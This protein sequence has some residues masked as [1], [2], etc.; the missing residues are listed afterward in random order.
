MHP[1]KLTLIAN[2][3]VLLEYKGQRYLIDGIHTNEDLEFDGVPQTLLGQMLC[4][5]GDLADIDY[6]LFTHEHIDHF[7][8]GLTQ[9]YLQNN[10]VKAIVVPAQ[11]GG[12]LAG[13]KEYAE[14]TGVETIAPVIA[15]GEGYTTTLGGAELTVGGMRHMGARFRDVQ[16]CSLLLDFE[17]KTLLF[18]GDSDHIPK[19]FETAFEGK[20]I[21]VMFVNPLFYLNPMGQAVIEQMAPSTLVI[22]HLAQASEGVISPFERAVL[23][24]A[25][26]KGELPY[27]LILLDR[28][29]QT[30]E[31]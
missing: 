4:G 30:E 19:W 26:K 28:M 1:V 3:G 21:D 24:E 8:A 27:Q 16:S 9:T 15:D 10:N 5:S 31:F 12:R 13:L 29:G 11:G 17:G 23:A 18:T 2:A 22:Y 25:Q 7:M 6:L 14:F 20:Q